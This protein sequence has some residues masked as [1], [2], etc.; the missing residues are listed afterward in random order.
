VMREA[1]G[2]PRRLERMGAASRTIVRETATME[3]M[4]AGFLR[5]MRYAMANRERAS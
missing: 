2:D 5:A 3:K 1:L 4:V